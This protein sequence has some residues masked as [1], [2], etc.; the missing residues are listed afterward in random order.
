MKKISLTFIFCFISV[1]IFAQVP[2]KVASNGN[3]GI[4]IDN[5]SSKLEVN[6]LVKSKGA[7]IQESNA[8]GTA[9]YERTDRSAMLVGAGWHAGFTIDK[10]YNFEIS[11][12]TRDKVLDRLLTGSGGTLLLRGVGSTGYFG[13]G[14]SNPSEKIHVGGNIFA[15]GTITPSDRRLKDN[16]TEF[17]DGLNVVK[18]SIPFGT[19]TTEKLV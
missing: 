18:I 4:N 16:V 17:K 3:V 12:N 2:L 14:I 19:N 7:T 11:A 6:G 9:L 15:T 13:F 1:A 5:P 10:D 8:S